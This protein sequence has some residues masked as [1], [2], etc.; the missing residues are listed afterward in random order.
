MRHISKLRLLFLL[1]IPMLFQACG[2]DDEVTREDLLTGTWVIETAELSDYT[3][4]ISSIE[5]TRENIQSNPL[6]AAEAQTFEESLSTLS[7]QLFPSGTTITFSDDN[8]YLL[9]NPNTSEN[10]SD[11]WALSANEQQITVQLG[12][13][14]VG[15]DSLDQLVFDITEL[16][17]NS[18]TLLLSIGE[19]DLDLSLDGGDDGFTLDDFTIEYTFSFNKQ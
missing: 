8:T 16:S 12:D 6:F 14:D 10:I 2:D 1:I 7:D 3:I 19:D 4:T 5:L 18:L 17:D 13:D 11:S 9:A 15:D